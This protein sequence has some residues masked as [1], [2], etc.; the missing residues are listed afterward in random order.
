MAN[1]RFAKTIEPA[2]GAL[3]ARER[4]AARLID[5]G[6]ATV[7]SKLGEEK[8]A[9]PFLRADVVDVAKSVGLEGQPAWRVFAEIRERKN[10]S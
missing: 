1:I 6:R 5:A 3:N 8:A 10:R 4:E 2:N 7:P 9:N